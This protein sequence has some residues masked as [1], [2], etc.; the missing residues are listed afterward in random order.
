[1]SKAKNAINEFYVNKGFDENAVLGITYSPLEIQVFNPENLVEATE[2][3]YQMTIDE[4]EDCQTIEEYELQ[5]FVRLCS[6]GKLYINE[7][8]L[9]RLALEKI[10]EI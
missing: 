4:L 6:N 3:D 10:D 8:K 1:M 9:K 2:E 5:H 7:D